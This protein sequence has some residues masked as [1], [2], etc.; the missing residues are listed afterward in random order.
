MEKDLAIDIARAAVIMKNI[1]SAS[2]VRWR[3]RS[4]IC[5]TQGRGAA[6][7]RRTDSDPRMQ[8]EEDC[9]E[10]HKT[11]RRLLEDIM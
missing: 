10:I 11:S 1:S 8:R 2:H 7:S 6:G 5:V 3:G 9:L 4:R